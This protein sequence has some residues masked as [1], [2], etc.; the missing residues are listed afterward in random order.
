MTRTIDGKGNVMT[1]MV[2]AAYEDGDKNVKFFYDY[3]DACDYKRRVEGEAREVEW[4]VKVDIDWM[5]WP[6]ETEVD[7]E[8]E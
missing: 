1:Y 6:E 4:D 3:A 5:W 2:T 8:T 7:D